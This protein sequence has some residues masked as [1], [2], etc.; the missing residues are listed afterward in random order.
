MASV[1]LMVLADTVCS[2]AQAPGQQ[3]VQQVVAASVASAAR[4]SVAGVRHEFVYTSTTK[5]NSVAVAGTFN[6]WDRHANPLLSDAQGKTWHTTLNLP[7]GKHSYK[8][9]LNGETWITDPQATKNE[10]D[11]KGNINSVLLLAPPDYARPAS[12]LDGITA[13]SA[14]LHPTTVPDLNYDRGQ[15]T[16][17]LRA[18]PGDLKQ[19]WLKRGHQRYPMSVVATND[20]YARYAGQVPWDR[21]HDLTYE[22][23]LVD[24]PRTEAFGTNGLG[25]PGEIRPFRLNAKEFKPFVVPDWVEGTVFYQIFPDRFANGDKTNDPPNVQPWDAAPSW[26]SRLGGDVSGVR[27]HLPYLTDLGISA[28]YFNPIF[29]SPSVHRYDAEDY[30][31]VDPQFGTN[32]EFATL[33]REL[34]ARGIRTVMDFVFNHTAT[35]FPPFLDIRNRGDASPYK[36]WYFIK[37][38]PVQM[39]NN[40][41]YVAWN[42]Y[43]SMPKLN[44]VNPA[45]NDYMLGLVNYWKQQVPLAGL[46]L[47]VATEVDMHF[48]RNLRQRVK[49]LDPQ[50]WIVGEAWGDGSPWLTGDQWDS[51]MNY[52]FL[53]PNRDFFAEGKIPPSTYTRQ[54]M[55][56]YHR[57]VPQVSRNM[58]NLLSSHDTARF[59]TLCHNNQDLDRLAATVQFTWVGAPSIYYGEELGM[60][61]GNDPDNR[62]GMEW[63]R[64]TPDNPMLRYYQRLIRLRNASRALQ[65]GDPQILMTNDRAQTLAYARTLDREGVIVAI[66]RSDKPQTL[67]IPLP[68]NRAFRVVMQS[69]LVDGLSGQRIPTGATRL[70]HLTLPPLRAAVLLPATPPFLRL[71]A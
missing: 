53:W 43:P 63:Q 66:N 58:M 55:D 67:D 18:R 29:K 42:N 40:P 30:H 4:A 70:L 28:V 56:L 39:Q 33:T 25:A 35:T 14:L 21:R 24:G 19:V 6:N 38:Y 36:D 49:G 60:Q 46:R 44:L 15:L 16:L 13:R 69:G 23:E 37:S 65:A 52:E 47:D 50:I 34:Q 32:A 51:K 71:A 54:L 59:L 45:T 1:C 48:W 10:D 62:R 2:Q 41:N 57:Y 7:F 8:F 64:A 27:Q 26:F 61:G 17:S 22:F 20:L 9:I 68:A 11:G 3:P 12:P 31:T 5:L